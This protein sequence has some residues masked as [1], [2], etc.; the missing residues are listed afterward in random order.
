MEY[1]NAMH[2]KMHYQVRKT[3]IATNINKTMNGFPQE[4][5]FHA[6][7]LA[8]GPFPDNIQ[9][10]QLFHVFQLSGHPATPSMH[11]DATI[12]YSKLPTD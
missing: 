5:Y 1:N 7:P 2:Q 11:S 8:F 6:N 10:H 3:A 9:I 12:K 4:Y